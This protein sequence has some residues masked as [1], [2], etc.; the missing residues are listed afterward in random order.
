M[1]YCGGAG[2]DSYYVGLDEMAIIADGSTSSNDYVYIRD[3]LQNVISLF[4]I[5]NRHIYIETY[6]GAS[7][8][9]VDG[10]N[11]RGSIERVGFYDATINVSTDSMRSLINTYKTAGDQTFDQLINNNLFAPGFH[12][13]QGLESQYRYSFQRLNEKPELFFRVRVLPGTLHKC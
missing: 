10:L 13:L 7:A 9:V 8:I 3:Y 2:D 11:S 1:W 4:S 6:W 5:E 12:P